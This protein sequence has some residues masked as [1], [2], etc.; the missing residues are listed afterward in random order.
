MFSFLQPSSESSC[1]LFPKA[2]AHP[3]GPVFHGYKF[4]NMA[5]GV[6]FAPADNTAKKNVL[7]G[8]TGSVAAIK[9]PNLVQELLL[10]EPKVLVF[11]PIVPS[12]V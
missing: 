2:F 10:V 7:V 6:E 8:V 9:V 4:V 3:L 1:C 5:D 11:S 12:L